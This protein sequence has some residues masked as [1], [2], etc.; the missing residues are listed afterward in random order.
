[1]Q[2]SVRPNPH[3]RHKFASL[4]APGLILLGLAFA[5]LTGCEPPPTPSGAAKKP[6]EGQKLTLS[7]P[8]AA[9]A[10][11]VTPMVKV[12]AARTGAEVAIRR[13]P[14]TATDDSDL[15]VIPST[16]LG[17]WA[18][19]GLLA[20]VPAKLRAS[21][22]PFQWFGLLPAYGER[23]V[24]WGGQTVAVPLTGDGFLL[25]YRADRL[26]DKTVVAE[27]QNR[28]KRAPAAPATWEEFADL[29]ATFTAVDKRPSLPPLPTDPERLL[30]LLS[31][32]ASC[33]DRESLTD[34]QLIARTERDREALA[35]QF[36]VVSGQPRLN[37]DGFRLASEW[38][39]RLHRE[40][41]LPPAGPDDP[42]AALADG[43]ASLALMSLD[44]L[45]KLPREKGLVPTRFAVAGVPGTRT[46][47][48]ANQITATTDTSPNYVPHFAGGRL[49]VVRSRCANAEIAFDLLAE[50]GSPARSAELIATPGLG[51]GPTRGAHLERERRVAWLGYGF[52]EERSNALQDAMRRYAEQATR[53]PTLGLRGPDR[54]ALIA[55]TG[56]AVR[57]I[58]TG[59]TPPADALKQIA[60]AWQALDAKTDP[61]TLLRWRQRAAGLN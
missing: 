42:A 31:R 2:H 26:A 45:A 13:T 10:D 58:G 18:E 11:A 49:G 44:Q 41:T 37:S 6:F 23:L 59:A 24:E 38:L 27:H 29:A 1:M 47:V 12:W 39:A 3:N 21:D 14:M 57:K 36:S 55:A 5:M 40:G 52:D 46:Y 9:F 16:Y 34:V 35:F 53:N 30:E 51:A 56:D 22:N 15:G 25:V 60:T 32:V 33:A 43:R 61:A 8:D 54:A 19:P 7:C 28:Y 20:P 4:L 17:E 50:L 48:H